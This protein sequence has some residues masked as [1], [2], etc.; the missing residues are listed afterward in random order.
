MPKPEINVGLGIDGAVTGREEIK[1]PFVVTAN[2]KA[3]FE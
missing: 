1:F 2:I 3:G